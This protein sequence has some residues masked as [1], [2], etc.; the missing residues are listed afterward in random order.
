MP[1]LLQIGKILKKKTKRTKCQE[2][3]GIQNN[4][5]RRMI[6]SPTQRKRRMRQA[7]LNQASCRQVTKK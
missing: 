3:T 5:L 6:T 2:K 7:S 1:C 4:F